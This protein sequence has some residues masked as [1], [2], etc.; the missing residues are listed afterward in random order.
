MISI[1]D[2]KKERTRFLT[3]VKRM[4]TDQELLQVYIFHYSY[5][6]KNETN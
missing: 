1:A 6:Y 2:I 5:F 3:E 4:A